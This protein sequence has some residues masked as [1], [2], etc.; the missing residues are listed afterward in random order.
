[1]PAWYQTASGETMPESKMYEAMY[2]WSSA[3]EGETWQRSESPI[4]RYGLEPDLLV[5]PSGR[6][7]A[8]VRYQ[9][10]KLPSDPPDLASPH[11]MRSDKPPYTK[12]K[13]VGKGLA[14]RLTAVLWSDDGGKTWTEPRLVTGFDE[15]TGSLVRMPDGTIILVF[16]HKTDGLGQRFML[17]YD[18]GETWTRCVF[19]LHSAGQYASS[20]VLDDETIATIIHSPYDGETH[21]LTTLM[22]RAPSKEEA[23]KAGFWTPR[24]AEPLGV[25]VA[26]ADAGQ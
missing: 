13:Q 24:V 3:D 12:S 2:F 20:V 14:A 17:S 15:Q 22:W 23:S 18:E 9:R 1:M 25:P 6:M 8:A 19:Q 10:H 16:G 21:M 26:K 7:L 11:L 4:C 5:L